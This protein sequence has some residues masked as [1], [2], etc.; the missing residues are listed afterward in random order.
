[1][2]DVLFVNQKCS[3]TFFLNRFHRLIER[4]LIGR[5]EAL[6]DRGP[7]RKRRVVPTGASQDGKR[8][9]FRCAVAS[10]YHSGR[11]TSENFGPVPAGEK[12]RRPWCGPASGGVALYL[13]AE[14]P[15]DRARKRS[16]PVW[17]TI[18][19]PRT[20]AVYAMHASTTQTIRTGAT[21]SPACCT[22]AAASTY[23]RSSANGSYQN[24]AYSWQ[25][26]SKMDGT[27]L[28]YG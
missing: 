28:S 14:R 16:R 9:R 17:V 25:L 11:V 22:V 26:G 21:I 10:T 5:K 15:L 23:I 4:G 8:K 7:A 3:D 27:R 18:A 2:H 19:P 6:P 12:P 1:M 13:A 20:S 24:P